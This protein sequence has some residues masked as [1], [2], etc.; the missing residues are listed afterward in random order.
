LGQ[1]ERPRQTGRLTLL[2]VGLHLADRTRFQTEVAVSVGRP[3]DVAPFREQARVDP[4]M[5]VRALT[6]QLQSVL[7]KL[8][9]NVPDV[10]QAAL[11]AAIERIY[12]DEAH[13]ESDA[14]HVGISR[15]M[16]ECIEHFSRVDP[17]RIATAWY[18]VRRY[19]QELAALRVRDKAVREML[20]AEGR[21]MERI[22]L[23]I[24]GLL[25]VGPALVGGLLHYV[26]YR[27]CGQVGRLGDPTQVAA[28]RISLAIVVFP[29]TYA[30][31]AWG[32]SRGL[33][34]SPR[35]V[36]IALVVIA[37]LGLHALAYFQWFAHQRERIR[38][39]FWKTVHRRRVAMLR[40]RRRELIRMCERSKQE[41]DALRR[42]NPAQQ[43]VGERE[44]S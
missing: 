27:L 40:K 38:L 1:E 8:I 19:E 30:A 33:G 25:G 3:I 16:A 28:F 6:E 14:P 31:I 10:D 18:R 7:E 39:V 11:V 5:A 12:L 17:D 29:L 23:L 9:V 21:T 32:L 44:A 34:W 43:P 2:P 15:G 41:F 36:A 42:A 24:V 26:P 4:Q 35:A 20:P 37:A 22:R 13:T